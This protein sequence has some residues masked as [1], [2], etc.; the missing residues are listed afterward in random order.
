MNKRS[1]GGSIGKKPLVI[2]CALLGLVDSL[3]QAHKVYAQAQPPRE[4]C[5]KQ[6]ADTLD[7][8]SNSSPQL[9]ATIKALEDSRCQGSRSACTLASNHL[10]DQTATKELD[11]AEK[12]RVVQRTVSCT[13]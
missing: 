3:T 10:R 7:Q 1:I 9:P 11:K 12:T 13:P 5:D 6:I 2:I 8:I 4:V